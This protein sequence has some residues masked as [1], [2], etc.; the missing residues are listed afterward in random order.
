MAASPFIEP[1][2]APV[3]LLTTDETAALLRCSPKTL[4]VD[5]CRRR[6]RVPFIRVGRNIRYDRTA[7][8]KW[9]ADRNPSE[10][11]EG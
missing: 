7:V 9:L 5:R 2:A 8:L 6:W 4:E 3:H 11:M 10:P 1:A